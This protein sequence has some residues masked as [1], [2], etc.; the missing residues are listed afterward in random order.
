MKS[1]VRCR[2]QLA[3]C[4]QD[5]FAEGWWLRPTRLLG[6]GRRPSGPRGRWAPAVGPAGSAGRSRLAGV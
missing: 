2:I 1:P 5:V 3:A 4:Y 6:T